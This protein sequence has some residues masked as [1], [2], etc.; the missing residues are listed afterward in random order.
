[1]GKNHSLSSV[2]LPVAYIIYYLHPSVLPFLLC[3][4]W[5][6]YGYC[7]TSISF[8]ML[9]CILG[10]CFFK[11]HLSYNIFQTW[12]KAQILEKNIFDPAL[13]SHVKNV[14]NMPSGWLKKKE[15]VACS[16]MGR[17]QEACQ[18]IVRLFWRNYL[19]L[20]LWWYDFLHVKGAVQEV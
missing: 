4:A 3:L 16:P 17:F 6:I 19:L 11:L 14:P 8:F 5:Y 10:C 12:V 18:F 15:S 7:I 13:F 20:E 9:A 1:M 2:Y